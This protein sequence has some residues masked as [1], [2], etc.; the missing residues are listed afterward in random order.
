MFSI[1]LKKSSLNVFSSLTGVLIFKFLLK[2]SEL[3][4]LAGK[5]MIASGIPLA[6]AVAA[7]PLLAGLVTGLAIGFTGT[8]FPL[9]VGLMSSAGLPVHATLVLAYGFG[10]MGMML[11]PIHLCLLVSKDYF[12]TTI[13]ATLKHILPCVAAILAACLAAYALLTWLRW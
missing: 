9:V 12:S 10:Y 3:L 1:L 7:L 5:E 4:P 8:S 11:S 2:T 6:V 13:P